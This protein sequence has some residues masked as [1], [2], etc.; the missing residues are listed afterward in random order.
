MSLFL[1][2]KKPLACLKPSM[3]ST[4]VNSAVTKLTRSILIL[5]TKTQ[6]LF[7]SFKGY[8][9]VPTSLAF[10]IVLC[11][12]ENKKKMPNLERADSRTSAW[13]LTSPSSP[14]NST[15]QVFLRTGFVTTLM[16]E[17]IHEG[18]GPGPRPLGCK[19]WHLLCLW[20]ER[21]SF[22]QPV[23]SLVSI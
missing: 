9:W 7:L 12:V 2:I 14:S 20:Y 22:S 18:T 15:G 16:R 23:Y 13:W 6:T 19:S 5:G 3:I 11:Q 1:Y 8:R 21:T 10:W 4:W 17:L